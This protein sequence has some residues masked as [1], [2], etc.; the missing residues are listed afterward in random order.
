MSL[1]QHAS[2]FPRKA[3]GLLAWSAVAGCVGCA[4]FFDEYTTA[5]RSCPPT[6]Q[7]TLTE[8]SVPFLVEYD[9]PNS[10]LDGTPLQTLSHT[11]IF[12][13]DGHG[14]REYTKH[15]ATSVRGG[16]HVRRQVW[17]PRGTPTP[18]TLRICATATNSAGEGP[19]TL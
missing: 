6:I 9:E 12:L 10:Q 19:P 15:S 7:I 3:I 14:A 16:G 11:T 8:A 2:R 13:D 17:L 18:I 5:P 1:G 4:S